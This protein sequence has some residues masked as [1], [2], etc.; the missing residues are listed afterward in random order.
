MKSSKD[1]QNNF[2]DELILILQL[3][4][5]EMY[6]S[7]GCHQLENQSV[8]YS[9]SL[10]SDENLLELPICAFCLR[11]IKGDFSGLHE[12]DAHPVV[13]RSIY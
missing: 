2:E 4:R 3:E 12:V 1:E 7:R 11:R 8:D 5:F 10:F 6:I 9:N 13:H